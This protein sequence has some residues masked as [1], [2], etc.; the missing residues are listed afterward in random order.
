MPDEHQRGPEASRSGLV[1]QVAQVAAV[2]GGG[3]GWG[4]AAWKTSEGGELDAALS[5]AASTTSGSASLIDLVRS[6]GGSVVLDWATRAAGRREVVLAPVLSLAA[7]SDDG[8][9][10]AQARVS[11]RARVRKGPLLDALTALPLSGE[12]RW[13]GVSGAEDARA[14]V[15]LLLWEAG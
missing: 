11:A 7:R 14:R 8:A 6:P 9:I 5:R 15:E 12:G 3:G 2:A 4:D 1:A 13:L 10:A